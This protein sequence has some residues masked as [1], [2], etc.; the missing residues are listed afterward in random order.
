MSEV[1][2]HGLMQPR[3]RP[4][5]IVSDFRSFLDDESLGD[6][7]MALQW[8]GTE[9]IVPVRP[10]WFESDSRGSRC[11]V[12]KPRW[13]GFFFSPARGC[14][15]G[16]LVVICP[17]AKRMPL[18]ESKQKRSIVPRTWCCLRSNIFVSLVD[19]LLLGWAYIV[20]YGMYS[21]YMYN[22]DG[23]CMHMDGTR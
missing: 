4:L 23:Y 6:V 15:R 11:Q 22:R 8:A 13:G 10:V 20:S 1:A 14:G 2:R 7:G 19:G 16:G 17:A 21:P 12:I 18:W 9:S 3:S 5:A